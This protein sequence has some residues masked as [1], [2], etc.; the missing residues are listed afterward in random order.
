MQTFINKYTEW[1]ISSPESIKKNFIFN[2]LIFTRTE[3]FLWND[4]PEWYNRQKKAICSKYSWKYIYE[5][6]S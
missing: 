2:V 4:S 6:L 5:F 1:I 3:L